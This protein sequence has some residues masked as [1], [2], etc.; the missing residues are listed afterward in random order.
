MPL[1]WDEIE[2]KVS[3]SPSLISAPE[4]LLKTL[5][6]LLAT[7]SGVVWTSSLLQLTAEITANNI[8]IAV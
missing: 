7:G 2:L 1:P 4:V 6:E 3:T 5:S 8:I